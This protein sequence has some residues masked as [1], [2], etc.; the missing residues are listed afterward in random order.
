MEL[1]VCMQLDVHNLGR[2][3]VWPLIPHIRRLDSARDQSI[4]LR[5]FWLG[6]EEDPCRTHGAAANGP[7]TSALILLASLVA[8]TRPPAPVVPATA[9]SESFPHDDGGERRLSSSGGSKRPVL[10]FLSAMFTTY[11]HVSAE[12]HMAS[13]EKPGVLCEERS[14]F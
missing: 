9:G 11:I 10:S 1:V 14:M 2:S 5:F 3:T 8:P 13:E 7:G 6:K 12:L 4:L